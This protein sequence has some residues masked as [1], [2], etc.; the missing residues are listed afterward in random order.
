MNAYLLL[1]VPMHQYSRSTSDEHCHGDL[2]ET[3]S[4]GFLLVVF[5]SPQGQSLHN[6]TSTHKNT[7]IVILSSISLINISYRSHWNKGKC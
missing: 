7:P 1:V 4:S 5:N 2:E 6:N 3:D